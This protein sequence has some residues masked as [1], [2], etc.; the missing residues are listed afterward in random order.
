MEKTDVI[1]YGPTWKNLQ[2]TVY[3]HRSDIKSWY[4]INLGDCYVTTVNIN[5]FYIKGKDM[6]T[7]EYSSFNNNFIPKVFHNIYL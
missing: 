3:T 7:I 5:F 6:D 1:D 2:C 4:G